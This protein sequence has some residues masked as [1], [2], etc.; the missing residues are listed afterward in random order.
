MAMTQTGGVLN[1]LG[2]ILWMSWMGFP[3]V[4]LKSNVCIGQDASRSRGSRAVGM[5]DKGQSDV[6]AHAPTISHSGRLGLE[7][8]ILDHVVD[9]FILVVGACEQDDQGDASDGQ[10][11]DDEDVVEP[12]VHERNQVLHLGSEQ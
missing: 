2:V 5:I 8:S 11:G 9:L 12:D 10:H 3:K 1:L 4:N 7:S 6:N